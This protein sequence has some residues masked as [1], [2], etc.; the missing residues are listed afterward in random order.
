MAI[1]NS[2]PMRFTARGLTDAFDATDEFKGACQSLANLIFDNSNPEIVV[3][4]PGVVQL[5]DLS[6]IGFA[7][8][9]FISIQAAIGTR[10]Y[11]M[12]ST[13]RNA[14]KDEPFCFDT[15]TNA[16]VPI[17]GVTG[18]NTPTSPATTGDWV[19]PT[20]ASI[21]V[22]IILTHPGFSGAGANFFGVIDLTVPSA[23]AWS[24]SNLATNPLTA[25]PTA[26]A[27]LNNRAYFAF[28]GNKLALSDVLLPKTRTNASQ[29]L[30][31]GDTGAINAL[32]GLPIQTTSSGI[33]S[34][35]T[36]FKST[37][38]WQV[39]GDP[40]TNNLALNYISLTTGTNSPRTVVLSTAGIYFLSTGGPYIINTLGLLVPL[41]KGGDN[42]DPDVQTPF[43]NAITPTRWAGSY[44]S[45]IY[46]CCG[47]TSIR[48]QTQTNDY[49][50][51]EHKRRWT[52]PHSFAYDCASALG[53]YF[54]LTSAN[55]PGLL[56][57]GQPN[58]TLSSVF[59]DLGSAYNVSVLSSTFPKSGEMS[60]KQVT[61]SQVELGG[62]P[63]GALYTV[64][65][66]DEQGAVLATATINVTLA[67]LW[68]AFTWGDGTLWGNGLPIWGA[69]G[70]WG[71]IA[72]GG[73]EYH[74]TSAQPTAPHTY[75]IP[76]AAPFVFDKMQLLITAVA[77]A[78]VQIGTF[79]ARYQQTGYM[80]I[81]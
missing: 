18:A 35:L 73:S 24:S 60:Q 65:A 13:S 26:V 37:Q 41:T 42:S 56:C 15:A 63:T 22:F 38:V 58:Q 74:W 32:A 25:V 54:V 40:T 79:Y 49:W 10:I 5:A 2:Q 9:R 27:N 70:L 36:V 57:R 61:E 8:P 68:G 81:K 39:A 50:F 78:T 30:V 47:P 21:G 17:T 52:G 44:N 28:A 33:L 3:P 1:N 7:L 62:L 71:S 80:T 34:I 77:S 67:E 11:G 6:Q 16:I 20:I 64:T 23:P 31:V 53:G 48:G 75:P 76:W 45:S 66:Q 69:G 14:G 72:Q 29:E 4:R 43:I 55:N 59:T 19:P 46:R 51:D 12:V